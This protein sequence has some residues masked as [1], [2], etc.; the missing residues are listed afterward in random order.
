M[1]SVV[2]SVVSALERGVN[3]D[4]VLGGLYPFFNDT[5]ADSYGRP[6]VSACLARHL[7]ASPAATKRL[8]S[9]IT[10]NEDPRLQGLLYT[11]LPF[12][13]EESGTIR[14]R[15]LH[16]IAKSEQAEGVIQ[17]IVPE[18]DGED[19]EKTMTVCVGLAPLVSSPYHDNARAAAKAG[20]IPKLVRLLQQSPSAVC[21]TAAAIALWSIAKLS[22]NRCDEAVKAG[23][24]E[25]LAEA[26]RPGRVLWRTT[27]TVV[28]SRL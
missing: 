16:V 18:L 22:G 11:A 17:A 6:L 12:V 19:A 27:G 4:S 25:A 7:L 2:A 20:A 28:C 21:L 23:A 3:Y 10:T 24:V 26:L 13:D 9:V 15:L 8:L 5:R 14:N 1:K